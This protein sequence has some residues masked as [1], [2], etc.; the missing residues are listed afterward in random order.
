MGKADVIPEVVIGDPWIPVLQTSGGRARR[1]CGGPAFAGMTNMNVIDRFKSAHLYVIT[2]SPKDG[3][4]GYEGM[5]RAACEGGAD[6]VQF[7]DKLITGRER[8]RVAARLRKIC[9]EFGV[10]FIVNDALEVA[11]AVEAD[12]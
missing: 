12:G 9:Q 3:P 7:R 11:L 1:M 6:I 8:Y 10:L 2:C 5:V 4:K